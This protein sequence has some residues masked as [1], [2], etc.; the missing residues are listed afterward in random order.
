M[1]SICSAVAYAHFKRETGMQNV[2]AARAGNTNE[3]IDFVLGKFGI[4][5][6]AFISD[7][8]PRVSDVMNRAV[9]SVTADSA[10][11]DAIQMIDR[12]RLRG[13]PVIDEK[14]RFLGLLSA[15][16]I[17]HLLFPPREEATNA[18]VILASFASIVE[19]FGGRLLCGTLQ[20]ETIEHLLLVGAMNYDTFGD[21][22]QR[23]EGRN[24]VLV[25]GDRSEI[26]TRAIDSGVRSIIVTGSLPV[27]ESILR[28]AR[29]KEVTIASSPYDT[30][31]TVL[32]ARGAVRAGRM[33]EQDYVSF[34][35]DTLLDEAREQG[36]GSAS[37]VFPILNEDGTL[38]GI[39][40]KS[41][42]LKP[43][44][45]QL[46]LVDHNELS[47]AVH[48]AD[49][50]P[51]IEVLDHHRL[52]GFASSSPILFWNNPVG[53]TSTL[54]TL[55]YRQAGIPIPP[56]IA[57]LLMA[58]LISDTLNL[59]SPTATPVD[60]QALEHLSEIAKT[61]PAELAEQ[62]FSVGSPLL[63][64]KPSQVVTADCKEYE[65]NGIRFSVAQIEEISFS[66]LPEKQTGLVEALEDYCNR[67]KL[68]FSALLVTDVNTQ[69]SLLL[70]CGVPEFL[71]R[72]DFPAHGPNTWEV[73]GIVSRKKQLLPYLLQ[74][75]S[76]MR[77]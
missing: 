1:D 28:A 40:S 60:K 76:G 17:S 26:Q 42:F 71:R 53:S 29:E 59:T 69:T 57:G 54:V 15:F 22:L 41:D 39:L 32:L 52:G 43:P 45:R 12:K 74:C 16:K 3:R 77:L 63:T 18:R 61:S 64:M 47:Q 44:S 2:I 56:R 35:P 31:T 62:I 9:I 10:V 7:M 38:A 21:T 11:Y 6:P 14:K 5:A 72:I 24:L 67:R 46:I 37:F 68:L 36:A 73:N 65:E 13:L 20:T 70:V 75:L 23:Y 34:S 58:G 48:G 66:H 51:I 55:S 50:V 49:R 33:I 4:E 27:H 19:T 8:S 25:V 30:A